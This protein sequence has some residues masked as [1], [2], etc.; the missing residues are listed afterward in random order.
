MVCMLGEGNFNLYDLVCFSE[1]LATATFRIIPHEGP[2]FPK[3]GLL[4]SLRDHRA[5]NTSWFASVLISANLHLPTT[6]SLEGSAQLQN[7]LQLFYSTS[8]GNDLQLALIKTS[9]NAQSFFLRNTN[10]STLTNHSSVYF[11]FHL[12]DFSHERADRECLSL[13]L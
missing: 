8:N 6:I 5:A 1:N 4:V 12:F 2:S 10:S 11:D 9:I 3:T 13:S 7:R